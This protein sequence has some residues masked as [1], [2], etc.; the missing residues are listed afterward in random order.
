MRRGSEG[1]VL[2]M[3]AVVQ[4]GNG[5]R[6]LTSFAK[7]YCVMIVREVK[8]NRFGGG[9]LMAGRI[10]L[11]PLLLLGLC[12]LTQ[13]QEDAKSFA[14]LNGIWHILGEKYSP[15]GP[16]LALTLTVHEDT[17]YGSGQFGVNCSNRN[18]GVGVGFY[19]K[20]KI[21]EDGSF[22]LTSE[23]LSP[24]IEARIRGH[25]PTEK[26][27]SWTGS[28]SI[29]NPSSRPGCIFDYAKDFVAAAYPS[30]RG[31]YTGTI[32]GKTLGAGLTVTL[33]LA[34]GEATADAGRSGFE[35]F[36]FTPL[37]ATID[38]TGYRVY[39]AVADTALPHPGGTD[40]VQRDGFLLE[41]TTDDGPEVTLVAS[42][43]D[44]AGS[45]VDVAYF[46]QF[47]GKSTKEGGG[48]KLARQ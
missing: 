32:H 7:R 1:S 42:Y 20:G 13:A 25:A 37:N 33:Q 36:Y 10:L 19:L 29:K 31:T 14:A 4:G 45:T 24:S 28:P 18:A 35:P 2:G 3:R 34:P 44:L 9:V 48:G 16:Y 11:L 17:V 5:A 15:T 6:K 41:F 39:T 21:A 40:Q 30:L 43:S 27:T 47:D 38:V 46:T 8:G 22:L 23:G 26:A 12:S